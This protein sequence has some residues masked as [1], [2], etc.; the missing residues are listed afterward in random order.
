MYSVP[1][2]YGCEVNDPMTTACN[3]MRIPPPTHPP[4]TSL[5]AACACFCTLCRPFAN[6]VSSFLFAAEPEGAVATLRAD[7]GQG[8]PGREGCAGIGAS[9]EWND[10]QK[11]VDRAQ[12]DRT[13]ARLLWDK[14]N[15]FCYM[16]QVHVKTSNYEGKNTAFHAERCLL[17]WPNS[18][19]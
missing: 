12:V 6:N 1:A 13:V 14:S 16:Q 19:N 4:F 2:L 5:H 8:G 10:N 9:S 15:R 18:G 11:D 7:S 17:S 3:N